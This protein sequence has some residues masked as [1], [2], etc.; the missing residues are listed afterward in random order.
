[1]SVG[2]HIEATFQLARSA[3]VGDESVE[4]HAAQV[5][6]ELLK[7]EACTPGLED[8]AVSLDLGTDEITIE[9]DVDADDFEESARR[10]VA[11]IRTAIHAAGGATP[12]WGDVE[13]KVD[14]QVEYNGTYQLQPA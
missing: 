3:T 9:V 14:D 12:M 5:M 11:Y 1:L 7:L 13:R 2:A 6:E 8:S 4:R 10:G